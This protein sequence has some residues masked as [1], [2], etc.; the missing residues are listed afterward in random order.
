MCTYPWW[1]AFFF[2]PCCAHVGSQT[3]ICHVWLF[4]TP[5][6]V[7]CQAPLSMGFPSQECWSGLPPPP[8]EDLPDPGIKPTSPALAGRFFTT[9]PSGKP[10]K[11]RR[12]NSVGEFPGGPVFRTQHFHCRRCGFNLW[13]GNKDPTSQR[14]GQKKK[15]VFFKGWTEKE[16]STKDT[17]RNSEG[18]RKSTQIEC[19][20]KPSGSVIIRFDYI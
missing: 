14:C 10:V 7:A 18:S 17:R 19:Q 2:L 13:L 1:G 12:N 5:W 8:P 4:G 20:G 16:D 9:E 6:T 15:K 3:Y 11:K